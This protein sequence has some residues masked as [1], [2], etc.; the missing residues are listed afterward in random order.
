M[1][2]AT[3]RTLILA[4]LLVYCAATVSLEPSISCAQ[5]GCAQGGYVQGGSAPCQ[6]MLCVDPAA[7]HPIWAVDSLAG[8]A[9]IPDRARCVLIRG[10]NRSYHV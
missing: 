7:P 1:K 8:C 4:D 2:L 5:S 9:A 3:V 10:Q 6:N